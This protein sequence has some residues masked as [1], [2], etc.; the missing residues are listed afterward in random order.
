VSK[1]ALQTAKAPRAE[2][3]EQP[4]FQQDKAN[5]NYMEELD[6][7]T[8]AEVIVPLYTAFAKDS[9][10]VYSDAARA[11]EKAIRGKV[12]ESYHNGQQAG[13]RKR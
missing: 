8:N 10:E 6:A 4:M 7:W 1:T 11:V 3:K 13:P 12:L 5:K 2:R 9:E